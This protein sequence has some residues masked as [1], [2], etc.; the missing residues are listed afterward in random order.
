MMC[1]WSLDVNMG[2]LEL[3]SSMPFIDWRPAILSRIQLLSELEKDR[4]HRV[5]L[6]Y[7]STHSR[8]LDWPRLEA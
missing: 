7:V 3:I 5:N 1:V 4:S 2:I 6:L 8:N